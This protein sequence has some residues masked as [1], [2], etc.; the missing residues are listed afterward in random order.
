MD[1][2]M[3]TSLTAA[4][5]DQWDRFVQQCPFPH[6]FQGYDWGH[7]QKAL[8]SRDVFYLIG[9]QDGEWRAVTQIFRRSWP[10][11]LD[12]FGNYEISCGPAFLEMADLQE[13]LGYLDQWAARRAVQFSIGPRCTME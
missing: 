12:Q 6:P 5:R 7:F 1:F 10:W 9:T 8:T 2:R 11:P 3:T 13:V 4:E